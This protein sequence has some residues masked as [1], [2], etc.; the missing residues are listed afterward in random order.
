MAAVNAELFQHLQKKLGVGRAALYRKIQA[1][2]DLMLEPN[3]AALNFADAKGVGI[4]R[5]SS[6]WEREQLRRARAGLPRAHEAPASPAP[7]SPPT[8][9]K[10]SR[11]AQAVRAPKDGSVFVVHGR[12]EALRKSMFDFL[13]SLGLKPIEWEKAV[14]KAK[15]GNPYVGDVLRKAMRGA[16]AIVVLFTP[17]EEA[18]LR[19]EYCTR[20]EKRTE[21]ALAN[22]ARPNVIF[23]AG[24]AIGAF[25]EKTI[26]AQV[27]KMRGFS[28][29]GGRLMVHLSD[30]AAKR[31][32]FAN[33][34]K[35]VG[36]KPETDGT[37][38]LTTGKFRA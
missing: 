2:N 10:R 26:L 24:W 28:D 21:G 7:V 4:R 8:S 9:G 13:R 38:W 18:R 19:A 30:D 35:A 1:S 22:Q 23:E 14:A 16:Q 37:D 36:C 32:T 15:G 5:Y 25:P 17:D 11:A 34:L 6:E 12:N 27:G 33:R 3:L 29:I 31:T 20:G